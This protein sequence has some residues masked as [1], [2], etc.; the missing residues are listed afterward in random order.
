MHV[1]YLDTLARLDRDLPVVALDPEPGREILLLETGWTAP[2]AD[3]RGRSQAGG[4]Q[5]ASN[6]NGTST[7]HDAPGTT[8]IPPPISMIW[9]YH[10]RLRRLK[11]EKL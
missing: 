7:I 11:L 8:V 1:C 6:G 2:R 10:H 9:L 5:K 3:R 4:S